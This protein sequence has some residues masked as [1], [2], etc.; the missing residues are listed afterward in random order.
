MQERQESIKSDTT[1]QTA[2]EELKSM[3]VSNDVVQKIQQKI[4]AEAKSKVTD[5]Q[6]QY[7]ETFD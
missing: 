6:G 7:Y 1:N 4:E 5:V 2:I 3:N